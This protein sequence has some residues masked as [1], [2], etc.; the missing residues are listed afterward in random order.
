MKIHINAWHDLASPDAGGSEVVVD[1]AATE[2]TQL[3][4]QVTVSVPRP[5]GTY[6]YRTV[7]SGG[8]YTQ[9]LRAPLNYFLHARDADVVIDVISGLPFFTPVWR[10]RK[11]TICFLHHIHEDQWNDN[12]PRPIAAVG[13]FLELQV[14]PRVYREFIAV[15]PSTA[16]DTAALGVDPAAIR[17][18][19]NG[20]DGPIE[21]LPPKEDGLFVVVA[22]LAPN[23]RIDLLLDM[24]DRVR[25]TTGGRLV[26]IGDGVQT[27]M[28]RNRRIPNCEFLGQV[29]TEV[30]DSYLAR[31]ALLLVTSRR[32]G[33]GLSIME[34]ARFA[35][36]TL[37][38]DVAGVRD[39]IVDGV[40]GVLTD[41]PGEFEAHWCALAADAAE[42][43]RLGHAAR[44]RS[45]EFSWKRSAE[46]LEA[47]LQGD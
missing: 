39:A 20:L 4:H 7:V 8:F 33:W 22:R 37:A 19:P 30:R 25:S 46:I 43:E 2:L 38:F 14:M 3:G 23:K 13:K 28:L 42:R 21:D 47:V 18:V 17:V 27:E 29:G 35:T 44:E 32:E 40:T 10:R 26:V 45:R 24:W 34:A 5:V 41:D 16:A 31:A 36:P 11:R 9:F 1:H 6:S 15:S 12:Y